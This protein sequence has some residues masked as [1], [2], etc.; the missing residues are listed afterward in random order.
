[1]ERLK[2]EFEFA[3]DFDSFATRNYQGFDI[4]RNARAY[5]D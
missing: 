5:N 1:M 2:S 3:D 4:G